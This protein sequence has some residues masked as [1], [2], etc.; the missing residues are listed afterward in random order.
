MVTG[1]HCNSNCRKVSCMMLRWPNACS[2]TCRRVQ[3]SSR[4]KAT[5]QTGSGHSSPNKVAQLSFRPSQID[6]RPSSTANAN[7]RNATS[8]NAALTSSSNFVTSQHDTTVKPQPT[9]RS[10]SSQLFV[11]GCGFMS[12]QPSVLNIAA[13][14]EGTTHPTH[15]N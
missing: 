10:Q 2:A 1:C 4:T 6:F 12:P 9:S 13:L 3:T 7:T 5:T 14:H 11:C 8:S 15:C